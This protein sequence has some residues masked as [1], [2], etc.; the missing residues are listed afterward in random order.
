MLCAHHISFHF[1]AKIFKDK[2]KEENAIWTN[3]IMYKKSYYEFMKGVLLV[4]LL[5]LLE[6]LIMFDIFL[7]EH[8]CISCGL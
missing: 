5:Y 3:S 8:M 4:F 7:W 2:F 1:K 6:K